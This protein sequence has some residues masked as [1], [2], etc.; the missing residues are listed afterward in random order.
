[1]L[2]NSEH[3]YRISAINAGGSSTP[4]NIVV[5]FTLSAP[6]S[7]TTSNPPTSSGSQSLEELLKQRMADA[8]RLQELLHGQNPDVSNTTP[9]SPS[10]TP[11]VTPTVTPAVTLDEKVNLNDTTGNKT[12]QKSENNSQNFSSINFGNFDIKNILYPIISLIGVGIVIVVLY[13]RKKQKNV[14]TGTLQTSSTLAP[15]ESIS[16]VQDDDYAMTILK[17]RLA[18]GEITIDE[19]KT[20]KEELSE[21]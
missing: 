7:T 17:N 3:S 4:S 9:P 10:V 18:K 8:Q 5:Q 1:M 14:N 6:A 15:T 12:T 2:P 16:E 21:P 11:T 19:Y 13:F 20:L